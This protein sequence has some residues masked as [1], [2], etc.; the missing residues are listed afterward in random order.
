MSDLKNKLVRMAYQK[1]ELREKLIPVIM[2][3]ES[4]SKTAKKVKPTK[5][6]FMGSSS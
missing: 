1:P 2:Q 4:L 6:L 3:Y 5:V